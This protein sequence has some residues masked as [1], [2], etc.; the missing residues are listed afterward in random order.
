MI[1]NFFR[2]FRSLFGHPST[3][4]I[5]AAIL[6]IT[7]LPILYILGILPLKMVPSWEYVL[8][9]TSSLVLAIFGVSLFYLI[10]L[11]LIRFKHALFTGNKTFDQRSRELFAPVCLSLLLAVFCYVVYWS[12]WFIVWV[13][14][15]SE[16]KIIGHLNYPSYGKTIYVYA[17]KRCFFDCSL[18]YSFWLPYRWLPVMHSIANF[19]TNYNYGQSQQEEKASYDAYLKKIREEG[20][21][22]KIPFNKSSDGDSFVYYNL[23]TGKTWQE[24]H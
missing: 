9:F 19:E 15:I 11:L 4:K 14:E 17:E 12:A 7:V 21:I 18:Y 22:V 8:W 13:D 24:N 6:S 3:Q 5:N 20:G 2:L 1:G 16:E 10:G 23:N